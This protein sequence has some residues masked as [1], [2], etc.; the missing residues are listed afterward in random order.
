MG[1]FDNYEDPTRASFVGEDEKEELIAAGTAL[2]VVSLNAGTT[3]YGPT[4][5]LRVLLDGE[6]RVISF[7]KYDPEKGGVESR[8]A[9]FDAMIEY[10]EDRAAERPIVKL[11]RAGRAILVVNANEE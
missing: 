6:E 9:L 8:D 5:F 3:K 4:Y 2:P 11:K 10:L 1:F 7:K